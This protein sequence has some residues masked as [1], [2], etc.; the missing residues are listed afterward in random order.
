MAA[1]G[2]IEHVAASQRSRRTSP[3]SMSSSIGSITSSARFGDYLAG[4]EDTSWAVR[5]YGPT[6]VTA[7]V[8]LVHAQ[9][10]LL[11]DGDR[12][13]ASTSTARSRSSSA[14]PIARSPISPTRATGRSARA[15]AFG[16]GRAGHRSLSERLDD[17]ARGASLPAHEE[18]DVPAPGARALRRHPAAQAL[19]TCRRATRRRMRRRRSARR[20]ARSR[21]SR[22]RTTSRSRSCSL[23]EITGD[24]AF[25]GRGRSRARRDRDD[26]RP[27]VPRAGP[28]GEMRADVRRGAGVRR[29]RRAPPI[30]AR[31]ASSITSSTAASRCRPIR[32][33]SARGATCRRST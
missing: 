31:R 26:A 14:S 9:Y 21:R 13:R 30:D 7:L 5:T 17:P 2:V 12:A 8:A 20:R 29:R 6:A 11:V 33:S 18:R 32:R 4:V 25:L 3:R 10:A 16:P 23:F 27:V 24:V 28:H 1:L 15:Y 19:A 22:A